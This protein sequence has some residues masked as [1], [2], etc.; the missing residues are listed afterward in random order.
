MGMN[1]S[2]RVAIVIGASGGIGGGCVRQLCADADTQTVFAVSRSLEDASPLNIASGK[3]KL[4][5]LRSDS[6]KASMLRVVEQIR[7]Q[8]PIGG[9][10]EFDIVIAT[11]LLH[12]GSLQPE[13][14]IDTLDRASA[15]DVL[16]TNTLMP[17]LWLQS[18]S[19]L[20]GKNVVARV[21]VLSARVGSISD[22]QLGGWY[23]YRAS[24]AALNM[25][26]KT[27]SVEFGRRFP[28]VKLLA[29]HPGTTKSQLSAPFSSNVPSNKLFSS[30][31]SAERLVSVMRDQPLD[32]TL[33]FVAW[34]GAPIEW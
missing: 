28:N 2:N 22:N 1:S 21:A 31:F 5:L 32:K 9:E 14:R 29:Y 10:P 11:G 12:N 13:K 30:D 3:S 25:M 26:L 33:S 20:F 16:E 24:K 34:D 8:L 23:S 7:T 18:L 27:L 17:M 15:L 4:S 6:S 19:S